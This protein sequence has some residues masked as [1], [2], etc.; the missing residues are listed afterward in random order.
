M[1]PRTDAH[2]RARWLLPVALA[3]VF[4]AN[5]AHLGFRGRLR[6]RGAE[7]D[8]VSLSETERDKQGSAG[9][10]KSAPVPTEQLELVTPTQLARLAQVDRRTVW[11]WIKDGT[12]SVVYVGPKSPRIPIADVQRILTGNYD[13]G[14]EA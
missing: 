1:M 5:S 12:V 9:G 14:D 10:G 11:R 6:Q 4:G 8:T 13:E 3:A 2:A 7:R